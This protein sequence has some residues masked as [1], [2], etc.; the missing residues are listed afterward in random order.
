M[1]AT[2]S[3]SGGTT[4]EP[5]TWADA[6]PDVAADVIVMSTVHQPTIGP[7]GGRVDE[8]STIAMPPFL[9]APPNQY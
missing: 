3:L 2:I 7:Y 6:K 5:L 4:K 8:A 1:G 9:T